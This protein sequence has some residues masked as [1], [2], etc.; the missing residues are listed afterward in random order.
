M[1]QECKITMVLWVVLI[2]SG[3]YAFFRL[4][5]MITR[6]TAEASACHCPQPRGPVPVGEDRFQHSVERLSASHAYL[7][8]L[9]E[10]L[11]RSSG[12]PLAEAREMLE[13][14]L[15]DRLPASWRFFGA[16]GKKKLKPAVPEPPPPQNPSD[17]KPRF[18]APTAKEK[19]KGSKVLLPNKPT[20]PRA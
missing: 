1:S 19:G 15:G 16:W 10:G 6:A 9:L 5:G 18:P 8:I 2:V 11:V 13:K 7:E 20:R 17:S 4:R 3:I 14:E 12:L